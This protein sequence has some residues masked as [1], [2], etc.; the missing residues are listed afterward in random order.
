MLEQEKPYLFITMDI[1]KQV[2]FED[3]LDILKLE[4]T[5][6]LI[7]TDLQVLEIKRLLLFQVV[8]DASYLI[9]LDDVEILEELKAI[10][11]NFSE[12]YIKI[13][14]LIENNFTQI[15]FIINEKVDTGE[16]PILIDSLQ[17]DKIS[18]DYI[19][20]SE[21]LIKGVDIYL[22]TNHE[23]FLFQKTEVH[24]LLNSRCK[25]SNRS[26]LR[27]FYKS[28]KPVTYVLSKQQRAKFIN[29][30]TPKYLK[31][32]FI[33]LM[34]LIDTEINHTSVNKQEVQTMLKECQSIIESLTNVMSPEYIIIM[35]NKRNHFKMILDSKK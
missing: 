10:D 27:R 9:F 29:K 21:K 16:V 8:K 33:N 7:T 2:N 14:E 35:K 32:R 11:K 24:P 6:N 23:E 28:Q 15:F 25:I 20:G 17:K 4:D 34:D 19:I 3:F 30:K 5:Y 13:I 18:L 12:F 26:F 31:Q 22:Y 1:W